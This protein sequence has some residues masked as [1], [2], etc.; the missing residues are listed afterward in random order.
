MSERLL[1]ALE[2][3]IV[4]ADGGMGT[5][6]FQALGQ[7]PCFDAVNLSHPEVILRIH[8]DFMRAGARLI[9]TNTFGAS[10][11]KLAGHGL[12]DQVVAIN[13]RAVKL[14]R[15]AREI[16]G[17][18]AL[19]AG[20][21]GPASPLP[22]PW[23]AAAREQVTRAVQEQAWA[24]EERGVDAF[25]LET[26]AFLEE[27]L[28]AVAAVRAISRLP[29]VAQLAFLEDRETFM[30][31][32]PAEAAAALARAG[33]DVIGA[34]CGVGPQDMLAILGELA[35]SGVAR[36]SA[37][38]NAGFPQRE[39]GRVIYPLST[40]RYFSEF[41]AEAAALGARLIGGCCGTTPEHIRAIAEAVAAL[42]PEPRRA[43]AVERPR[44]EQPAPP[45]SAPD[46]SPLARKLAAGTFVTLVELDP[47]KGINLDR[48]LD[49]ATTLKQSGRVD[50][51][52]I[53]N[54][55]M[56][57]VHLDAI[58]MAAAIERDI[59][60]ETVP[61]VT[62][63]DA[64]VMGL[65]ASLLGAWAVGGIRNILA[66]TG[67]PPRLGE[68]PGSQGVYEVDAIGLVRLL[69]QLNRGLDWAGQAIGEPTNFTIGVALTPAATDLDLEI[70]RFRQK[71]EAGA[72]FAM[73]QPIFHPE[74]WEAFLRRL[75]G[76]PPIP[77]LI[78]VWPVT[79]YKQAVRLH[80]EVPG[81]VIPEPMLERMRTAGAQAGAVGL[82]VAR[83]I[84]QWARE[85]AAG[86][87][88]I[89]PFKRFEDALLVLG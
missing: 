57:R 72:E 21:I 8:L 25:I 27:L 59:G 65:Q 69:A 19:I 67:D 34:N 5:S 2:R 4:I 76:D 56:A 1:E 28:V 49:A 12:E 58:L 70:S 14:A 73:T 6:I 81:I 88:I 46:R 24:L 83:S 44:P 38:P 7:R 50:A 15:E 29:I 22:L 39:G 61:H 32:R 60:L 33:A 87:Y 78:G 48:V 37:Q 55:P 18:D 13:H 84:Y 89:P 43:R 79:S 30:G 82:E 20:S 63:R 31:V 80:H 53:N 54:S 9:E 77:I 3:G 86:A 47:P 74:Q 11:L 52:D 35:E 85:H 40:P 23:D 64:S 51:A 41:A 68:H 10:R 75:G 66:V 17:A 16:A 42:G 62:T 36:L 45:A 71:V 26:Y